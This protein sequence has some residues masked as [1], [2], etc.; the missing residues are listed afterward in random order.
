MPIFALKHNTITLFYFNNFQRLFPI[1][2]DPSFRSTIFLPRP[3]QPRLVRG[4]PL[5]KHPLA[6]CHLIL[7]LHQL[8][9][10]F[11]SLT[12]LHQF[13]RMLVSFFCK[14]WVFAGISERFLLHFQFFISSFSIYLKNS[15]N[16]RQIFVKVNSQFLSFLHS[17]VGFWKCKNLP[18]KIR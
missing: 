3:D 12:F 6:H 16:F 17:Y 18:L 14:F 15:S 13:A 7:R 5:W 2:G 4:H 11:V 8:P 1:V 10:I 9:R